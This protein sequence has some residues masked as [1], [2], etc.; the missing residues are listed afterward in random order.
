M[1]SK[2]SQ[3]KPL[4][5]LERKYRAEYRAKERQLILATLEANHWHMVRSA[6][7]LGIT[8]RTLRYRMQIQGIKK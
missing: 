8:F 3:P 4:P 1:K 5:A 2:R 7:V 6:K